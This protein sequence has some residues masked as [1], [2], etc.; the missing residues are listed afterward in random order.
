VTIGFPS[1]ALDREEAVPAGVELVDDDVGALEPLERLV[2][3]PS[4]SSRSASSPPAAAITS[5]VPLRRREEGAWRMTGL[6][7][8]S[9]VRAMRATSIPGGITSACGTQRIALPTISAPA[10]ASWSGVCRGCRTEVV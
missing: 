1:A 9:V 7:G 8:P 4:T 3:R 10:F 2:G 5:A 6:A